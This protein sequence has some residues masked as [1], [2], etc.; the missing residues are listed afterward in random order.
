MAEVGRGRPGGAR[1]RP[2]ERPEVCMVGRRQRRAGGRSQSGRQ[3]ADGGPGLEACGGDPCSH[4]SYQPDGR[5]RLS[6]RGQVPPPPSRRYPRLS[7]RCMRSP[8]ERSRRDAISRAPG[9]RALLVD[10]RGAVAEGWHRPRGAFVVGVGTCDVGD[11]APTGAGSSCPA[12]GGAMW[13]AGDVEGAAPASNALPGVV[14]LEDVQTRCTSDASRL[15]GP[16]PMRLGPP[17]ALVRRRLISWRHGQEPALRRRGPSWRR[18]Q[19]LSGRTGLAW[20]R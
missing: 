9:C 6:G 18:T 20:A 16:G 5:A 3:G 14:G 10:H 4:A 19:G 7:R 8:E 1:P 2:V 17:G 12:D 15:A 13:G 11:V